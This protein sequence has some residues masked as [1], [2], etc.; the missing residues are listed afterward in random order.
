VGSHLT[1]GNSQG[2]AAN[3]LA[4]AELTATT[5]WSCLA[6]PFLTIVNCVAHLEGGSFR[7]ELLTGARCVR[8]SPFEENLLPLAVGLHPRVD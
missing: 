8:H 5:M 7:L 6:A 2:S 4:A 1:G 3:A